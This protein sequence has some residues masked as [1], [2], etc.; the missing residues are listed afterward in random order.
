MAKKLL[1]LFKD[2]QPDIVISTHPF[3]SQ[4]TSYLK[5]HGKIDCKLATVLTDFASHPQW[6]IG[7][8]F[9]DYFFVSNDKM[10]EDLIM[11]K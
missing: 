1:E 10:R 7:K 4:M 8:E 3:S 11:I 5:E 6:L 2:F 9:G